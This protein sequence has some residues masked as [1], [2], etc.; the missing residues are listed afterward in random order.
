MPRRELPLQLD[1]TDA[2]P[3]YVQ[4]ARAIAADVR[5]GRLARGAALPGTRSLAATLGVHRNTVLAAYAEL[6]AEGWATTR[7]GGGTFVSEALPERMPRRIAA[8]KLTPSGLPREPAFALNGDRGDGNAAPVRGEPATPLAMLGGKPDLRL[9][10]VELLA[11]AYRRALR[12][13]PVDLL[14]YGAAHGE[15]R[16]RRALADL[17]ARRRG[18][19][20]R[21]DNVLVTRGSHMALDLLARVLCSPGDAVAVEAMGYPPAWRAFRSVGAR[22]LPIPVDRD[23]LDVAALAAAARR[24]RI[25]AVYVTPHHQYPTTALLAPGRRLQLLALAA[26]ERIA[27]IEDDYDHEFHYE[28]RPV[29]PLASIDERGSVIYLGT[30]SKVLAPGLRVGFVV[31]PERVVERLAQERYAVDRQGDHA[32]EAAIAEL[33]EDGELERHVRKMCRVYRARRDVLLDALATRLRGRFT[34]VVPAGGMAIW[35][36]AQGIDVDAWKRRCLERGVLF[37]TARELA[38]DG[39]PRP[40]VRL[41]FAA[42]EE[43]ELHDAVRRIAAAWPSQR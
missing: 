11:R 30:L 36:R 3:L 6:V 43:A 42:L 26:R 28:G 37:L 9:L 13:N 7:P 33:I 24:E 40:F 17:V 35:G 18:V 21:P 14:D 16:L 23:G 29:L 27:I 38:F 39:R 32:L 41:G 1:P 20:A 25:R 22:L 8:P 2:L 31:A 5:R 15:P 19:P 10:P 4:I 12:R 34:P